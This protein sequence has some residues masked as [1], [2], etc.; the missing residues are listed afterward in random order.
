MQPWYFFYS[1]TI[2]S[3][4]GDPSHLVPS[5][6]EIKL[7][8]GIRSK[9][10]LPFFLFF[11]CCL[12][13]RR[14]VPKTPEG[15]PLMAQWFKAHQ[16]HHCLN[17]ATPN[18]S[19]CL[20]LSRQSSGAVWQSKASLYRLVQ[21]VVQ[22]LSPVPSFWARAFLEA[23]RQQTEQ[24]GTTKTIVC[25]DLPR[26]KHVPS[27]WTRAFVKAHRQQTVDHGTTE[28]RVQTFPD[29]NNHVVFYQAQIGARPE[30]DMFQVV[31]WDANSGPRCSKDEI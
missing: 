7:A 17:L 26:C 25:L 10:F 21:G 16:S 8:R 28:R 1:E 13:A 11:F 15:Q 18:K 22:G 20:R 31:L 5:S 24:H 3:I 23:H 19:I 29:A 12:K 4:P 9:S 30:K 6:R 14:W 27:L 2:T